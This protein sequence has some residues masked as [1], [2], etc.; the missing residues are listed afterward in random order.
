M[1]LKKISPN[2]IVTA[3]L[4]AIILLLLF[5]NT[6]RKNKIQSLKQ[7]KFNF[8]KKLNE[9]LVNYDLYKY[10]SNKMLDSLE[11]VN[12]SFVNDLEKLKVKRDSIMNIESIITKN[13]R[14]Q[15][16]KDLEN[17]SN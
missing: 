14:L 8:E 6:S 17:E 4:L 9:V 15:I 2:N 1:I 7:E 3:S 5:I 10:D 12:E 16:L 13:E 11:L